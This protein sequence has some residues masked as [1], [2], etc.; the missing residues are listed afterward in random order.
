VAREIA[1]LLEDIEVIVHDRSR[2]DVTGGLYVTDGGRIA[3]VVKK[4]V[5]EIYDALLFIG[6]FFHDGSPFDKL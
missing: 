3:A 6:Q 5:D 2:T 4:P 1:L